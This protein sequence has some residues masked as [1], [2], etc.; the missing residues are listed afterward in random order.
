MPVLLFF[1]LPDPSEIGKYQKMLCT[2]QTIFNSI[3][4]DYLTINAAFVLSYFTAELCQ[5]HCEKEALEVLWIHHK[6]DGWNVS[7]GGGERKRLLTL[8]ECG[9][10]V[11]VSWDEGGLRLLPHSVV[12]HPPD[13]ALH[14]EKSNH[15]SGINMVPLLFKTSAPEDWVDSWVHNSNLNLYTRFN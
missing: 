5:P 1:F 9:G 4:F 8:V 11:Y 13:A 14:G 12:P 15:W 7:S 10:A 3:F 6:E 2:S